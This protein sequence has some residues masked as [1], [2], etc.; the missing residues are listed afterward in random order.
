MQIIDD[1]GLEAEIGIVSHLSE[2]IYNYR[3]RSDLFLAGQIDI[4]Q[5]T[6]AG[7]TDE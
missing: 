1:H 5:T 6:H 4:K 2:P 7:S 3:R